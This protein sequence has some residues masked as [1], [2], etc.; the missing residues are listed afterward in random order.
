MP[1]P[2][3]QPTPREPI[4]E[5]EGPR[6]A[7]FRQLKA[8]NTLYLTKLTQI[9]SA[10][11]RFVQSSKYLTQKRTGV[12]PGGGGGGGGG[13]AT[14]TPLPA[15]DKHGSSPEA[16][17]VLQ[18]ARDISRLYFGL[19]LEEVVGGIGNHAETLNSLLELEVFEEELYRYLVACVK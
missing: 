11:T 19:E 8:L 12:L 9:H 14:N 17:H 3:G 4:K 10:L 15:T 13:R 7:D 16:T 1:R 5:R 6:V 2:G 18:K